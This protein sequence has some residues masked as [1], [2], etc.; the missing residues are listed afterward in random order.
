MF[1]YITK[2]EFIKLAQEQNAKP[3]T[4]YHIVEKVTLSM[5]IKNAYEIVKAK[6]KRVRD[7]IVNTFKKVKEI[8]E[9]VTKTVKKVAYTAMQVILQAGNL[10][11]PLI[12]FNGIYMSAI[13]YGPIAAGIM[14]GHNLYMIGLAFEVIVM[15]TYIYYIP[16][17]IRR[18]MLIMKYGIF[19]NLL[20]KVI[21]R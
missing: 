7:V 9:P 17:S 12:V 6:T 14:A 13:K 8:V 10:I 21:A 5:K 4:Q 19:T 11:L 18:S 3:N 2:E 20:R 15:T 1:I 16:E